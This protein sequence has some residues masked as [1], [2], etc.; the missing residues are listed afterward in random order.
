MLSRYSGAGY[1]WLAV[2][3]AAYL[4]AVDSGAEVPPRVTQK[5]FYDLRVAYRREHPLLLTRPVDDGVWAQLLGQ[6]YRRSI[7]AIRVKTSSE[8]EERLM[9]WMDAKRNRSHF[10]L[11]WNNCA[12][13]SREMLNVLFPGAIR[14]SVLFDAGVTTPEQLGSSLSR[15][16]T[17]HPELGMTVSVLPQVP[18]TVRRSGRMYGLTESFVKTKPYLLPLTVFDPLEFGL[19]IA[20]GLS[21]RRFDVQEHRKTAPRVTLAANGSLTDAREAKPDAAEAP[22]F[23]AAGPESFF[24][25]P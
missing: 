12:D 22:G 15:Y 8:Q 6:S 7:L 14:R 11:F 1:D 17:R 18:G 19:V 21:D 24:A 5:A 20:T 23:P 25:E 9:R 13:L 16:A 10:N 2:P 3:P 4:Y